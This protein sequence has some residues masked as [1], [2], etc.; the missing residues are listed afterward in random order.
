MNKFPSET[1]GTI[2]LEVDS[3]GS[4]SADSSLF[5]LN[6][7]PTL[8]TIEHKSSTTNPLAGQD[9]SPAEKGKNDRDPSTCPTPSY[10]E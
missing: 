9:L 10:R 3:P 5:N 1:P 6:F 4:S 7:E 8:Y 2:I